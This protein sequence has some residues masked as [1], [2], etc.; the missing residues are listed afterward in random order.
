MKILVTGGLG[1][2]GSRLCEVLSQRYDIIVLDNFSNN[3]KIV[4]YID[5]IKGDI[6]VIKL[7]IVS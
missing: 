4:P 5:I 1:K 2:I 6:R 7:L 3:S